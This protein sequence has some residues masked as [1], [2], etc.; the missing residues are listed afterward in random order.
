M[1]ADLIRRSSC[2]VVRWLLVGALVS[3]AAT[4]FAAP[5]EVVV[6]SESWARLIY[7][8]EKGSPQGE[9]VDFVE[10]MNA[11]QH[12]YHF[13]FVVLPRLRL[14]KYFIDKL[15]DVYPLRTVLWTEPELN[16]ESTETILVS[17]DVYVAKR[18][19]PYGGARIFDHVEARR[20]AGVLGYHYGV[21]RNNPDEDEIK[22]QF[23][24][25][26][27]PSNESVVN[28]LLADRAEVGIVP[29][30]IMA[31]YF[32]DPEM[33]RQ[34]IV[35]DRFDSQVKFSNLVRK[36]GPISVADMN[37][38]VDLL[39]QSGDVEKLKAKLSLRR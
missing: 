24:V 13:K 37:A 22:K 25:D 2:P 21:F 12:K 4:A 35:G 33:R 17:G 11:V 31:R 29:E 32:R 10:R 23:N 5:I 3:L 28:F 27:L 15:A 18:Q 1:I 9:I 6:A 26:F 20:L 36:G 34:L 38:I 7:V 8:D 16:L 30:F 39:I 19:N 14:N